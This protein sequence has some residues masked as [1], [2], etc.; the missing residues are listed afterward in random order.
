MFDTGWRL[1]LKRFCRKGLAT[2]L[3]FIS[4][5]VTAEAPIKSQASPCEVFGGWS[6]IVPGS[7]QRIFNFNF[8]HIPC[9]YIFVCFWRDSPQWARAS[10]FTRFPYHTPHITV[11][12]TP[13]DEWSARR[14]DIYLTTY[15]THNRQTSMA[16]GGIRTHHLNRWAA[17][18]LRLG[19]C[20]HWGR[21]ATVLHSPNSLPTCTVQFIVG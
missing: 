21:C 8:I 4:G 7:S 1:K 19:P 18:D 10:S 5:R 13:L 2:T 15:T 9:N 16:P 17:A 20:G 14:R 3:G 6:D 11:G 12:K